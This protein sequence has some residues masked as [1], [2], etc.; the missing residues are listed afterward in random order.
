MDTLSYFAAQSPL[1]DPGEYSSMLPDLPKEAPEICRIIQGL[2]LNHEERYKYPI[3]NE[4]L[5]ETHSRYISVVLKEV[6]A[7]DKRPLS[8]ARPEADRFLA[9]SSDYA[10]LFCA[11]ARA[12]G[13]PARKRAGFRPDGPESFRSH[14]LAEYWD[15]NAWQQVDPSGLCQ[16]QF[17]PAAQ[18]WQACRSGQ[19]A[20]EQFQDEQSKGLTVVR[21]NLL[22]DLAAM[23]KLELL[24]WD[25]Y[26][27]MMRPFKDFSDRAWEI[28][29]QV[30]E[31][32]LA[33]DK[34][35]DELQ[36]LYA[37]EEGIQVPRVITCDTPLVPPH[38]V[39]LAF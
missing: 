15:G 7:L 29:D 28:L 22:L 39:E 19:T 4:R 17:M 33:G 30:A 6:L 31:L 35:L 26:G 24:N 32:L 21:A 38:K 23:N 12:H 16:G 34:A 9:S 10:N 37:R 2:F 13:I 14:E 1:T 36:A 20:P 8:E 11:I 18:A 5:L 27:W 3:V 25:R